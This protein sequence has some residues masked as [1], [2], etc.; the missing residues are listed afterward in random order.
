MRKLLSFV[1]ALALCLSMSVAASATTVKSNQGGTDGGKT[2]APRT[3]SAVVA[4]L[5][6]TACAAGGVGVVAYKKSKE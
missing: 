1:F 6:A 2:T 4:V 3:G 5:S